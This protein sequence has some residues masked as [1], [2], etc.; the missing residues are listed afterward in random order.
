MSRPRAEVE[1][2]RWPRTGLKTPGYLHEA[3]LKTG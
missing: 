2:P 3:R 1:A